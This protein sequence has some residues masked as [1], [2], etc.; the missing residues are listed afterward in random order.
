MFS[1]ASVDDDFVT[2]RSQANKTVFILKN[3]ILCFIYI[4]YTNY[5]TG[6]LDL[7]MHFSKVSG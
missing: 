7:L 6:E 1:L 3:L 5:N 2:E 4:S